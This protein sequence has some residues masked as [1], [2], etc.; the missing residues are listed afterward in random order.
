MKLLN[1]G[2]VTT[3]EGVQQALL[4]GDLCHR[5][6][7]SEQL[8]R[9]VQDKLEHVYDHCADDYTAVVLTGSGTA[10]V[11]AMLASCVGQHDKVLMIA[12]GIY[13]Y[14]MESI[15]KR[16]AKRY[17]LLD[18]GLTGAIDFIEVEEKLR[19]GEF[20]QIAF[21]HNETTVGRLNN[22]DHIL[23]L[24]DEYGVQLLVDGVSSF[25]GEAIDFSSPALLAV[26]GTANK[27]VHGFPGISF[28]LVRTDVLLVMEGNAVSLYLDL[29]NHWKSQQH[30]KVAF[31]P[32]VQI[33][34]ALDQALDELANQGGWSA[35]QQRYLQLS[36]LLRE[37]YRQ[38]GVDLI[39][40]EN[41]CASMLSAF[42]LPDGS[43][44]TALHKYYKENGYVI[45]PGQLNLGESIFRIAVMGDLGVEDVE[46]LTTLMEAYLQ[47]G[48]VFNES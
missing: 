36:T 6:I 40:S 34:Y 4:R 13:G 46:K 25:A 37:K 3:T 35:R 26:A 23:G 47:L 41:E 7:E 19:H 29:F 16:H 44:F 45:Y 22:I 11:E 8:L 31:T 1:P 20:T 21:V 43:D 2:P 30:G 17:E 39:I 18:F 14:R 33:L 24:C 32:A 12:N 5:E 27:C 10:A 9:S 42:R 48:C 15:L 28:V 38:Q